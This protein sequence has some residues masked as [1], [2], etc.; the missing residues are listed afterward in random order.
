[1]STA[2]LTA[3]EEIHRVFTV[4]RLPYWL[5][6]GWAVDF[7]AGH[8]TRPHSDIDVAVWL[9]DL[10]E[11]RAGLTSTGWRAVADEL[12]DGYVRLERDGVV[13]EVAVLARDEDGAI[14]TPAAG[15]R[16]DWPDESFGLDV[17][18]LDGITARVVSRASLIVD[19]SVV[20]GGPDSAAKDAA[21]VATLRAL[22]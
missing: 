16:G 15:G 6:G 21:D 4:R 8:V 9:S 1:V 2:Q 20:K 11:V 22:P 13:A 5:F 17:A 12:T 10:D 19:K 7:H 14:Y 18:T 3:I